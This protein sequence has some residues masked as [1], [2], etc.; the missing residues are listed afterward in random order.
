MLAKSCP[1]SFYQISDAGKGRKLFLSFLLL[2]FFMRDCWYYSP[3]FFKLSYNFFF[4]F[5]LALNG[6]LGVIGL[7]D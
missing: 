4:F 7:G 3:R 5:F 2:N 1:E 6:F